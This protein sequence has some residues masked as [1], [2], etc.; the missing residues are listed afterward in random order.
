VIGKRLDSLVIF[1]VKYARGVSVKMSIQG[2]DAVAAFDACHFI[3]RPRS[4]RMLVE[5]N[6]R[7]DAIMQSDQLRRW[8]V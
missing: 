3:V 1:D 2:H 5:C 7:D 4:V 6:I 8:G